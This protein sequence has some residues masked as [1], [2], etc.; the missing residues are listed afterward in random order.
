MIK[1]YDGVTLTPKQL[2]SHI[3]AD[4]GP[5]YPD[6]WQTGAWEE[7]LVNMTQKEVDE[8]N[9]FIDI[10]A[11]RVIKFLNLKDLD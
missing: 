11:A 8:T 6:V 2:A 5:Y 3:V 4:Y 7:T 9:R 1:H 10:Q